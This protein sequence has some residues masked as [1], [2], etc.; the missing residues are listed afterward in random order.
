M[1]DSPI[2]IQQAAFEDRLMMS[3]IMQSRDGS[4]IVLDGGCAANAP[5]LLEALKKLGAAPDQA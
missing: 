3:Y 4:I 5:R 1:P 2:L